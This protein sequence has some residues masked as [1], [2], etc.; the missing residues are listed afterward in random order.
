MSYLR[1][2]SEDLIYNS[3]TGQYDPVPTTAV[4]TIV[5]TP[6]DAT[7][8]FSTG[9]VSGNTCTVNIG[10]S[11]TY[12]VSKTGYTTASA[13]VTVNAD[14]SIPVSLT[15]I[16]Y[17]YAID[18]V[19]ADATVI[20]TATGYTQSGNSITVPVNTVVD[21]SV[22]APHY[23]TQSGSKTVTQTETDTVTLVETLY[24]YTINP[25]PNDATVTLSATGYSQVGNSI[26]VPYNT[27]VDWSV[28]KANYTTQSGT[29]TVTETTSD[30]ITL[31]LMPCT[32]TISPTPNDATVV[33][34][35]QG[36]TQTGN[37]IIVL[38]GT[39]VDY[40][41]SKTGYVT[42]SNSVTVTSDTTLPIALS[43]IQC[44][45]TVN[46]DPADA[47][48]VLTAQG[49]SQIGN[50]I[51]VNYGTPVSVDVSK[52]NYNTT[53]IDLT[54]AEVIQDITLTPTLT[55]SDYILT[56]N[57]TPADATVTFST[58]T[59][60]QDGHSCTVPAGTTI[61]YTVSKTKYVSQSFSA[62]M[63]SDKTVS[64]T[65]VKQT[66]TLIINT[67]PANALKQ[68][69][70]NGS[71]TPITITSSY[72]AEVD[73][74]IRYVITKFGYLKVDNSLVL[75]SDVTLNIELEE[76]FL[77]KDLDA[78]TV[79][80]DN[81]DINTVNL[82]NKPWV[83]NTMAGAFSNCTNLTS[84][85][86]INNNVTDMIGC[87]YG[88][89][90][91]NE[92]PTIPNSVTGSG[93]GLS[94]AF[95]FDLPEMPTI[96][97]SVDNLTGMFMGCVNLTNTTTIPNS[98]TSMQGTFVRCSN[99]VTAPEI[100]YS[101][102]NLKETFE[103]CVNLTGDI[104]IYSNQVANVLDCFGNT[105]AT[106]NVYIPFRYD[107]RVNTTTYNTFT[108][109]GYDT[110]GTKEGVYLKNINAVFYT[111]TISPTPN[112]ATVVLTAAGYTQEGNAITVE[113]DTVVTYTVSKPGYTTETDTI[114]V[115][116]TQTIPVTIT[117][118][119]YTLTLTPT[120]SDATVR[121]EAS[122]YQTVSGTGVQSIS[123]QP[124]TVVT[125][126][127]SKS[128]YDTE[129][130]DVTVT[131]DPQAL[132][133][134]L[135]AQMATLKLTVS[136]VGGT[137]QITAKTY[138]TSSLG[139]FVDGPELMLNKE[140]QAP[141]G[142]T[143]Y[144]IVRTDDSK[145]TAAGSNTLSA[146]A[147]TTSTS[148]KENRILT[149]NYTPTDAT[150]TVTDCTGYVIPPKSTSAGQNIYYMPWWG[151]GGGQGLNTTVTITGSATNYYSNSITATRSGYNADTTATLN[152]TPY[153]YTPGEVI[154]ESSTPGTYTV[155]P[156]MAGTYNIICV[157]AGGGGCAGYVTNGSGYQNATAA[158]GGGSGGYSNQDVTIPA[159]Q[160]NIIVGKG[161]TG[162][163]GGYNRD[164][165]NWSATAG[166]SSSVSNLVSATGGTGASASTSY[167][168]FTHNV[169][170]GASY[171]SGGSGTTS[172]G[173]NGGS[174]N[175]SKMYIVETDSYA[176]GGVSVYNNYGKGGN[177]R[178][179]VETVDVLTLFG[180]NGGSGYIKITYLGAN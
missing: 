107:N 97:N 39:S 113:E 132:A 85:T 73:T 80:I 89:T 151:G 141:V 130:D 42:Q 59:V 145:F 52:T 179:T 117:E 162:T 61:N 158:G 88:C 54:S 75:Q 22:S 103:S 25:T 43:E 116:S 171:G 35:A 167:S 6:N 64:V 17:T 133:V 46:P 96:P 122:G 152:L 28:S 74:S 49:Y 60:S 36:Y 34:T 20:L 62:V 3:E 9:T 119:L 40:T 172:N 142:D 67:D 159:E 92:A 178:A 124:N 140:M 68:L 69:Y 146:G 27:L 128:G 47:T 137:G 148:A 56:V 135:N 71:T 16:L 180:D 155:T 149:L 31:N 5:P 50:T 110:I 93:L 23:D 79:F 136:E 13:T 77:V 87:F 131:Q 138:Y 10:T 30:S 82:N 153:P 11:V 29:K 21:W 7:V 169:S 139:S 108:A 98:V 105:S 91:L 177:A 144:W 168:S 170:A 129:T 58:G 41:V 70:I 104:N 15:E 33:L 1:D 81:T 76:G 174:D 106:K 99:L 165:G 26:S 175:D 84:V 38:Y 111:L 100:P 125:Y 143:I 2:S 160:I 164:G 32:F 120:P 57:T 109:A 44:T 112:D 37:S 53:H 176:A 114:T 150:I 86:N 157:G 154:F 94:F 161:G 134:S 147:N 121:L 118:I 24:T 48:V 12:T 102:T 72:T 65:L 14:I 173:N 19:P 83:N 123:V 95:C 4:L 55:R 51:T 127:V 90:S 101:V 78:A 166:G 163:S 8:T 115:N 66:Y 45:I 18:P 126:T 63:N 156:L